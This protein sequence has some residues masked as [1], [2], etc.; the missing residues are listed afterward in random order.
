MRD[1][2]W[3]CGYLLVFG[4]GTLIGM[5]LITTGFAMPAAAAARHWGGGARLIRFSTGMLSLA[6]GLWLV[7]HIGWRDGLFL[8]TPHWTPQ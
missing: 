6:F 7:Y 1:A 5:A 3:A 2:R 8:A 4:L